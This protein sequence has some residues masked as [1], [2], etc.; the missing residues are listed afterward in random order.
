MRALGREAVVQGGQ[1]LRRQGHDR[2]PLDVVDGLLGHY[3]LLL[4]V[5]G[6]VS[7]LDPLLID[8]GL[9]RLDDLLGGEDG[10]GALGARWRS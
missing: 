10:H 2:R 6:I 7:E 8:R 3:H 5:V 9:E 1:L 4:G